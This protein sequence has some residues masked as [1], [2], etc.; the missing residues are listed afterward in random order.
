MTSCLT[1]LRRA[2]RHWHCTFTALIGLAVLLF[3]QPVQAH[4]MVA[5]HGTLNL[6]GSGGFVVMA[7]PVDAF[8]GVD[9]DG[10]GLLSMV[11]MQAHSSDI[12]TQVQ[13]GLQ[14]RDDSGPRPLQ[15]LMIYLSPDDRAPT[16]PA[17]QLVALGRFALADSV[18]SAVPTAGLLLRFSLFGKTAATQQ[19]NIVVTQGALK[20]QLVL[21]PASPERALFPPAGVVL[22][23]NAVRGAQHVLGGM[24]HLL[25]L[26]VVLATGWRWRQIVLALTCFTAGHAITLAASA[27]GGW[28]APSAVVEPAI[29]ATIIGLV[30][31]DRWSRQRTVPWPHAVR[32][33]LVFAA[34]LIHGLG[35]AT[36]LTDLGL[37]S[38]H[39]LLSLAGFNMGIEAGQVVV[40]MLA[41]A[42]LTG[43]R[44]F[45][46]GAALTLTTQLASYAA[47]AAGTVWLAQR[48][49][50]SF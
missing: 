26:L 21:T 6:V 44:F 19:Q 43:I 45:K 33:G 28:T 35:L 42:L 22:W 12:Q 39:R 34:A 48:I 2:S 29:A 38:Q 7:L 16:A 3:L 15:A 30:L 8:S 36:A 11:E 20:Q 14:L 17:A 10:D 23:E 13:L 46:G 41:M 1:C 27:L 50:V 9:D 4:L 40:A 5:Q 37:D 32:L 25:F 24:D 31:F 18:G 47:M 49:A